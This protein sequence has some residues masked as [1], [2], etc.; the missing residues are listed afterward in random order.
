M[1]S[2]VTALNVVLPLLF[3]VLVGYGC[4]QKQF[5]SAE[6]LKQMNKLVFILLIPATLL[7]SILNSSIEDAIEP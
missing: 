1:N 5:F 3:L 7:K 6:T 2:F 4:K